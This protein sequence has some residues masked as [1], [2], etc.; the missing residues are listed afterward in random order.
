[1]SLADKIMEERK[2]N[3]WS[4]EELAEKLGVSRQ[5]VSKWESAGAIPDLQ[6]VIQLAELY[7]VSTDYLLRDDVASEQ[8]GLISYPEA[9]KSEPLRRV[10][11]EESKNFLE[12]REKGAQIIANATALCILSPVLLVILGALSEE[13]GF[14]IAEGLAVGLG[15]TVRETNQSKAG[16]VFKCI[17]VSRNRNLSWL[18]LLDNALGFYLDCLAGS[19]SFVCSHLWCCKSN[20]RS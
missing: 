4:Q 3:G 8:N 18:E 17:L 1:M 19:R 6:R 13:S 2:R 9:E 7:G 20:G 5:A 15:C 12:F 14:H 10:S 11:M 16:C